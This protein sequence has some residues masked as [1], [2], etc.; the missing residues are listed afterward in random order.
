MVRALCSWP[1]S[2]Q[3]LWELIYITVVVYLSSS[4]EEINVLVLA[5]WESERVRECESHTSLQVSSDSSFSDDFA[6]PLEIAYGSAKCKHWTNK[7]HLQHREIVCKIW[8]SLVELQ[9][10]VLPF[11][12]ARLTCPSLA[13]GYAICPPFCQVYLAVKKQKKKAEINL[14][15]FS[16][17]RR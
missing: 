4:Q 12:Q 7:L 11:D 8:H 1:I 14:K 17:K 13:G 5:E 2:T 15:G 16:T 3:T 9:S 6:L 10:D